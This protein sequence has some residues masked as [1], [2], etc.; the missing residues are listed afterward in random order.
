MHKL[1]DINNIN[2]LGGLIMK[3]VSLIFKIAFLLSI[4]SD[5]ANAQQIKVMVEEQSSDGKIAGNY[6]V[7]AANN[8]GVNMQF[9]HD[10]Q[11]G[12]MIWSKPDMMAWMIDYGEGTYWEMTEED[13][14]KAGKAR[15]EMESAMSTQQQEMMKLMEEQMKNMS[16]EEK[17]MMRE[18]MPKRMGMTFED[19]KK[20]VYEKKGSE[21]VEG[22]G[23]ADIYVGNSQG[24][25][26][27][28][29][30]TVNWDKVDI[31]EADLKIF[32]EFQEFM[33]GFMGM[34]N[35]QTGFNFAQIEDMQGYPGFAVRKEV[36]GR[37]GKMESLEITKI[38][39]KQKS[40]PSL[41]KL[42]DTKNLKKVKSPFEEMGSFK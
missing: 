39:E 24:E 12:A 33:G 40:D 25:M 36:Y 19:D 4:F 14:E 22:W 7:Y 16:E 27:E 30:W 38:V 37:N 1:P 9:E 34:G 2:T 29:V 11:Q 42:S 41:Y 10:K 20:M 5:L 31:S 15:H 13:S 23:N 28:K 8:Y 35:K 17:N 32:D 26:M 18:H 6:T 3:S 21:H